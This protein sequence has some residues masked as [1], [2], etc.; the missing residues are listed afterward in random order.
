MCGGIWPELDESLEVLTLKVIKV[1]LGKL[2]TFLFLLFLVWAGNGIWGVKK[3]E[4]ERER[5]RGRE[6]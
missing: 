3:K 6:G 2:V 4:R 5:E 1:I